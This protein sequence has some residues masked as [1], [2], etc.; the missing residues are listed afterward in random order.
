VGSLSFLQGIFPTQESNWD[1]LYCRQILYQLRIREA[2]KDDG[3]EGYPGRG[4]SSSSECH[5]MSSTGVFFV[6]IVQS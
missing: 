6:K 2:L 3:E 5:L 4:K 1:P